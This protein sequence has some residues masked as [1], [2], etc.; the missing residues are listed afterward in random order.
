MKL[1]LTPVGVI[2]S[3]HRKAAGVEG[4][5]EVFS[6]FTPGLRDIKTYLPDC[7]AF[8]VTRIGGCANALPRGTADG[9]FRTG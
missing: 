3:P 5:G 7:E 8:T 2:R 9:R 1:E 4:A 6:Q